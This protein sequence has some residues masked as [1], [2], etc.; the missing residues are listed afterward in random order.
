M[1]IAYI[2][3]GAAGTLCGNCLG[4]NALAAALQRQGHDVL[5]L[6][7]YTPLLTD[8]TNVSDERVVFSGINLYLQAKYTFFRSSGALDRVLD[9]PRLLRWVSKFGVD[10]EPA[11]LGGMTQDM[12]R[13]EEGPYHREMQKL[14]ALL[15]AVRPAIVH[16]TNSMLASIAEPIK[17]HLGVPVVCSL[18]G[19]ADFLAGLPEPYREACYG[20]LRRHAAYIDAFVAPCADQADAMA[21]QLGIKAAQIET[22]LPGISLDGFERRRKLRDDRFVVGFLA[23]ISE[24]KGLHLLA[25]AV[26]HLRRQHPDRAV[27]LRVAGWRRDSAT[28]YLARA[29][30]RFQFADFGYLS[31]N[32]KLDFLHGLDAFSVP[33]TYR[34]SK[35]LYVLEAMAAGVPVVQPRI[36]VFPELLQ[37]TGGGLTCEAGDSQDLAAKLGTLMTDSVHADHLGIGGQQAVRERFH[38][39]RM[40]SQTAALYQQLGL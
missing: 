23:R 1:T 5:L 40:A 34:A 15:Q 3:A 7:A 18:Q 28:E 36:G 26:S 14:V 30:E 25:D 35:G 12:L 2:T 24:E 32:A 17:Q 21:A 38:I 37:A 16:L 8:D 4:D 29:G 6:P 22:V 10:T 20:L 27:E 9:N 13:G 19:E 31:R 11:K 39:G 33:T